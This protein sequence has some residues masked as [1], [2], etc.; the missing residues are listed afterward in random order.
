[1]RLTNSAILLGLLVLGCAS[2]D[3]LP[4]GGENQ[5]GEQ[6][7]QTRRLRPDD[8][9]YL[10]AF[11]M[12]QNTPGDTWEWS[13]AAGGLSYRCDGDPHGK[14]D[15]YPGSLFATG[16]AWRM[17]VAEI[18]IPAP[19]FPLNRDAGSL[20]PAETIQSFH[21]VPGRLID[22]ERME[23]LRAGLEFVPRGVG[24]TASR[25]FFCWAEHF[26]DNGPSHGSCDPDLPV[27][28]TAG[29]WWVSQVDIYAANDYLFSI[30]EQWSIRNAPGCFLATGRFRDG[31]WSGQGPVL[32]ALNPGN[33]DTPPAPGEALDNRPLI[34]Y[35]SSET[36][37][38]SSRTME[39]YHHSDEW[40]GGAWIDYSPFRAVV[41][42]GTKGRGNCWYG[43]RDG[44]CQDCRGERGWWSDR[45]EGGVLFYDPH[46]LEAVARG[47]AAPHDP[48][49]YAF[50]VV[51][52]VLLHVDSIQ[53]WHHLGPCA[54]DPIHGILYISEPMADYA[55]SVIHAWKIR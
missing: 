15:G 55:R 41:F 5:S 25:L 6:E 27:P 40:T 11:R 35:D 4:P 9:E 33:T 8:L 22:V 19:E 14:M 47:E 30:P 48:Q 45:F 39:G 31:G 1:M 34:L 51:D 53:Q 12:P 21:A 38:E 52:E 17:Q 28:D 49:P 26:Q 23:I 36:A 37:G 18:S 50:M 44:P 46:E 2:R 3:G 54:W 10:G 13:G 43:D 29:P 24:G 20:P 32:I 16:H 7:I 42:V